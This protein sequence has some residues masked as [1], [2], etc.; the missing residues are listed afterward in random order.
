[1]I[2]IETTEV[3]GVQV[4]SCG[5]CGIDEETLGQFRMCS[6]CKST[7]YC[8]SEC[9]KSHWKIHKKECKLAKK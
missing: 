4:T 3:E 1:M 9:Q 5:N 6:Q 8:N 7:Y 2:N